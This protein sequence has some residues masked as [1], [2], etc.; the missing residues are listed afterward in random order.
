[1]TGACTWSGTFIITRYSDEEDTA[2]RAN[3][4]VS[5]NEDYENY[6]RRQIDR[7]LNDTEFEDLNIVA[8][9]KKDGSAFATAIK[10]YSLAMLKSFYDACQACLNVLVEHNSANESIWA[11]IYHDL[12]EPYYAKLGYLQ[13]EISLRESEINTIQ[14][15][16][17][18][19][20]AL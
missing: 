9:F 1:M 3:V 16:K 13:S 5:L 18:R 10:Q 12:Y 7:I 8:L 19:L 20:K 2:T 15:R 17:P 14:V 11:E 4:S 6:V